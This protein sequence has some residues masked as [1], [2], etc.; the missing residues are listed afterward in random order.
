MLD[1]KTT[2]ILR[3][4]GRLS[5]NSAYKVVTVEEILATLPSK[6]YDA[7]SIKETVDFLNKQ[8][9]IVIKFEEDL[10]FCYSLLPKARIYLET[11]ADKGKVKKTKLPYSW[12]IISGLFSGIVA[13]IVNLIF[14]LLFN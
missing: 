14:Y 10:T 9:Y 8:E 5:E 12:I 3:S 1:K 2:D 4:L 6:S 11:E 13:S 7:D